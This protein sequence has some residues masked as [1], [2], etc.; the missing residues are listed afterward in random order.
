MATIKTQVAG[1]IRRILTKIVNSQRRVS[2][3]C[4]DIIVPECCMYPAQGLLDGVFT[5]NDLPDSIDITDSG[6][7]NTYSKNGSIYEFSNKSLRPIN[8]RWI[9]FL[10]EEEVATRNQPCL[11]APDDPLKVEDR[12]LETYNV[13]YTED[14]ITTISVVVN[15]IDLCV[16]ES[17]IFNLDEETLRQIRLRFIDGSPPVFGQNQKWIIENSFLVWVKGGTMNSP[18]GSYSG[19]TTITIP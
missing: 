19:I 7:T 1:G 6:I 3:S 11:I 18:M 16:W 9:Q 4:C 17:E 15:R 5:A 8:S 10:D 2:C 14:G 12:F 13:S